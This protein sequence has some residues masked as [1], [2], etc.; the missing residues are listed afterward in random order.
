[1]PV[2]IFFVKMR[3][4]NISKLSLPHLCLCICLFRFISFYWQYIFF[5]T[6][7]WDKF[8]RK[9]IIRYVYCVLLYT[10]SDI[11][12]YHIKQNL[13]NNCE[14]KRITNLTSLVKIHVITVCDS[15]NLKVSRLLEVDFFVLSFLIRLFCIFY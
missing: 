8:S 10:T 11:N 13:K 1:M 2:G 3:I 4:I 7:E 15:N 9:I 12:I 5:V 6:T 14:L